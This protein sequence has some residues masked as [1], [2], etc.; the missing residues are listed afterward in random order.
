MGVY[1]LV[2]VGQI[3]GKYAMSIGRHIGGMRLSIVLINFR[4][5]CHLIPLAIGM[6]LSRELLSKVEATRLELSVLRGFASL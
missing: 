1:K 3:T 6:V 5:V 2:P 4:G